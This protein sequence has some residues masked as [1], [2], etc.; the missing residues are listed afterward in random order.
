[1]GTNAQTGVTS[2]MLELGTSQLLILATVRLMPSCGLRR[3]VNLMDAQKSFQMEPIVQDSTRCVHRMTR[4]DQ[5]VVNQGL[6]RQVTGLIIRL[7]SLLRMLISTE[8]YSHKA[9]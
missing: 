3:Q 5:A 2:V 6:L 1:M 4:L 7:S 9:D 8:D